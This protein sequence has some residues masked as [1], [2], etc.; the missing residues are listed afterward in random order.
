MDKTSF[1]LFSWKTRRC[2]WDHVHLMPQTISSPTC[3]DFLYLIRLD[4]SQYQ[5]V[6]P[7]L[8]FCLSLHRVS[9]FVSST[10]WIAFVLLPLE[11]NVISLNESLFLFFFATYLSAVCF[12][13][14]VSLHQVDHA[15]LKKKKKMFTTG[16]YK[17]R[18][19]VFTLSCV[20]LFRTQNTL[21]ASEHFERAE[22]F[23]ELNQS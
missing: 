11:N 1:W 6:W 15:T 17:T 18:F 2:V 7:H 14:S 22:Y 8:D 20:L 19:S 3:S 9:H 23:S 21:D 12:S 16:N 10:F 4:Q 5:L 13:R